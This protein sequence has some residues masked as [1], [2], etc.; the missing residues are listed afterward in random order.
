MYYGWRAKIGVITPANGTSMEMEFHKYAPDGVAT[1][2]QRILFERVDHQGLAALA[3]RSV[4]AAK[5]LS[6]A[7]PDLLL[8]G[9]TTG[10][11]INGFGYDQTLID[12][13]REASGGIPTITTSTALVAALKT[14]GSQ[15][16]VIATPY[17]DSVNAAEKKFIED[18]GFD[19]LDI[20]GLGYTDPNCMPRTTMAEM[21]PLA[22]R[23]LVPEADTVFISCTGINVMDGIQAMEQ[24][25]ARPVITSNQV[26]LW[27]ALKTLGIRGATAQGKLF[28]YA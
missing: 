22:K 23:M 11:L 10:S 14:L 2:T 27:Y 13:I 20:R 25:F 5:I 21:Y 8:F 17:P 3:D 12:R 24:D 7:K 26:T 28:S 19:V 4:E 6:S 15:K 1:M 16:L 18:S 9:C